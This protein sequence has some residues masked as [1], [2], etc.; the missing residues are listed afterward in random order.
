MSPCIYICSLQLPRVAIEGWVPG[1]VAI[2]TFHCQ[3]CLNHWRAYGELPRECKEPE[4]TVEGPP[5][6]ITGKANVGKKMSIQNAYTT[7]GSP[8]Q[9]CIDVTTGKQSRA[10]DV[11]LGALDTTDEVDAD[12]LWDLRPND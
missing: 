1:T 5:M 3:K 7:R 8:L 12:T 6:Y 4:E 2:P 9:M 11:D 10:S